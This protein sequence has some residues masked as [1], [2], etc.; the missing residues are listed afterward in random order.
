M[1]IENTIMKTLGTFIV[2]CAVPYITFVKC[3]DVT[4]YIMTNNKLTD[5]TITLKNNNEFYGKA[6]EFET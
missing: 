3:D 1:I 5:F 4:E 6:R 2:D